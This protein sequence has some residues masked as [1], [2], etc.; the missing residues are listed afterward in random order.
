MRTQRFCSWL[1]VG[2]MLAVMSFLSLEADSAM[3]KTANLRLAHSEAVANIRH[4]VTIFFA[5]RVDDISNG[6]V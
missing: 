4:D 5:K 1:T 6:E 2:L 3:A